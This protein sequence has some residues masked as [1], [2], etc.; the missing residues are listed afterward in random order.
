MD[1]SV[2]EN[3][4]IYSL[5]VYA[6]RAENIYDFKNYHTIFSDH[7]E[8]ELNSQYLSVKHF[9]LDDL[10]Q[11][12]TRPMYEIDEFKIS[13]LTSNNITLEITY[14][15]HF[16]GIEFK[17]IHYVFGHDTQHGSMFGTMGYT[18]SIC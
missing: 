8:E 18:E 2:I 15:K 9:R 4:L 13:S 7:T 6:T 5:A 12:L 1:P 10:T 11:F 14:D 16:D 3:E 17:P